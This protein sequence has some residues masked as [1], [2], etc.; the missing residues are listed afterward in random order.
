MLL[1]EHAKDIVITSWAFTSDLLEN[2][3]P[4]NVYLDCKYLVDFN[5]LAYLIININLYN[6]LT[7]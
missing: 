3:K 2:M 5:W 6:I 7:L 4:E 1:L